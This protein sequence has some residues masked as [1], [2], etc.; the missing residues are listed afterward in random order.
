[1][2]GPPSGLSPRYK[3]R[4]AA[5]PIAA[6]ARTET[7]Q[8]QWFH[9][10]SNYAVEPLKLSCGFARDN[11]GGSTYIDLP[12]RP[13]RTPTIETVTADANAVSARYPVVFLVSHTIDLHGGGHPGHQNEPRQHTINNI[14]ARHCA[15]QRQVSRA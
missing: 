15:Q 12:L 1:M 9:V 4:R 10:A 7:D 6:N 3:Y 2:P 14:L 5:A 11:E 13:A 8:F